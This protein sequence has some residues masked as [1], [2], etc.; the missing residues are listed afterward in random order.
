VIESGLLTIWASV[1]VSIS[2]VAILVIAIGVMV[3]A[4]AI[5]NLPR[6]VC[7]IAGA[8]ILLTLLPAIIVSLWNGMSF[9]QQI[10]VAV[11]LVVAI[12]LMTAM[13]RRVKSLS[14]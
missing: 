2:V 5:Q 14:R 4:V 11:V 9:R 12:S 1:V 3:R 7:V 13:H 8:A 6:C 10:G